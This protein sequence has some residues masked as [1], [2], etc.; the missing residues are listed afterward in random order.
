M[1]KVTTSALNEAYMDVAFVEKATQCDG[2]T[3]EE[4]Q[5]LFEFKE[6]DLLEEAW[7]CKSNIDVSSLITVNTVLSKYIRIPSDRR[8]RMERTFQTP[9]HLQIPP[10]QIQSSKNGSLNASCPGSTLYLSSTLIVICMMSSLSFV[11][12]LLLGNMG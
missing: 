7:K 6:P 5:R 12:Q 4:L 10:L 3:C 1:G 8:E 11:Y 2:S 9:H